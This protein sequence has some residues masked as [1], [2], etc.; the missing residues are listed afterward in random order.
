MYIPC[1]LMGLLLGV[2]LYF[3]GPSGVYHVGRHLGVP[4]PHLTIFEYG[5]LY[6]L[7]PYQDGYVWNTRE[8]ACKMLRLEWRA[9]WHWA[10]PLRDRIYIH[11]TPEREPT[12][13]ALLN[14]ARLWDFYWDVT[15]EQAEPL[16]SDEELR[17][18]AKEIYPKLVEIGERESLEE[19]H[20]PYIRFVMFDMRSRYLYGG[21]YA[22]F[23]DSGIIDEDEECMSDVVD[24]NCFYK[25][26]RVWEDQPVMVDML[27]HELS[28]A[29]G[30]PGAW[31]ES[32]NTLIGIEVAATEM[33]RPQWAGG[34]FGTLKAMARDF[35]YWMIYFPE[36]PPKDWYEQ[37]RL[38]LELERRAG[39]PWEAVPVYT[40]GDP[41][42]ETINSVLQG[43]HGW[44]IM[45][46][47]EFKR[48]PLPSLL[49]GRYQ[50][51]PEFRGRVLIY[52]TRR[53]EDAFNQMILD[54]YQSPQDL[55]RYQNGMAHKLQEGKPRMQQMF[56]EYEVYPY[57]LLA[58]S[59]RMNEPIF[60]LLITGR[61]KY[62]DQPENWGYRMIEID[63]N[64]LMAVV[65]KYA[66]I[67][68]SKEARR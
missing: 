23:T 1:I 68:V 11:E 18:L 19:I 17:E 8:C 61:E 54:T 44:T 47:Q 3:L 60:V 50:W 16:A 12:F 58:Y 6:Y 41:F 34:V 40:S 65:Q 45:D 20:E 49:S 66:P 9:G 52:E 59:I 42:L 13:F 25:K 14:E 30:V 22:W 48:D 27:A 24:I 32:W 28:H 33:G 56:L 37:R 4:I 35:A 36:R 51:G 53:W 31:W 46:A 21:A 57:T 2:A 63:L 43:Q 10:Y 64:D 7:S 62:P 5:G 67:E 15:K 29:Q 55:Y 38:W 26:G 39:R